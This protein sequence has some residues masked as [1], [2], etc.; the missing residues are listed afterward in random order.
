VI[1][2]LFLVLPL[3]LG[4]R[5][6]E[7]AEDGGDECDGGACDPG[8]EAGT[9]N[10]AGKGGSGKPGSGGSSAAGRGGGS[11]GGD[12]CDYAGKHYD[13]GDGFPSDDGCN[14]CSCTEGGL[15]ACTLRA[16]APNV[17]G[18][19]MGR[20]CARGQYCNFPKDAQCGA[21]D[22]TGTC[23][24]MPGACTKQYDPVCGCDDATY[25]NACEAAANG[26]SVLHDG[27]CGGGSA[28]SAGDGSAG[29]A[30][31]G[32]AGDGGGSGQTCGGIASLE[33]PSEDEFCNYEESA[34]GQGCDGSISDAGGVCQTR[35][36]ACTLQYDPV[37]GCDRRTHGNACGAH[38]AGASVLHEGECTE[39][40][41]ADIGGHPVDGT[42]PGPMCP[43]GEEDYGPIRYS[44]GMIAF[45]GTICCVP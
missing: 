10:T 28:G 12:G 3:V 39:I 13:V 37:C 33:C 20:P 31:D 30:G 19:L 43:P 24:E 8:G 27:E 21:A 42:G 22:Q 34:G 7:D 18:G 16:C 41:C 25:G 36:Q 45:E 40:D 32:S 29:S 35:P 38:S 11:G 2:G 23:E 17:C 15:V 1:S 9:G 4:A 6:C 14:T 5:D 44:N 26:V